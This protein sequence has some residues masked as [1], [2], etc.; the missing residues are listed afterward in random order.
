MADFNSIQ[1]T[2]PRFPVSG[3]GMGGR[4]I[5]VVR[6]EFTLSAALPINDRIRLF[7][8]H[9]RF[10]VTGG[11]IKQSGLGAGVTLNIGDAAVANRYFAASAASAAGT[12]VTPAET[13]R[14][15]LNPKYEDVFATIAGAATATSGTLVV[16]FYGYIEEPA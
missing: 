4:S 3:P 16:V 14:D 12:N 2:P 5:K 15:Y 1:M 8:L 10:R 11:F 13:G 9:P 6:G 7:R